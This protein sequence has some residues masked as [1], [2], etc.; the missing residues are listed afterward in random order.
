MTPKPTLSTILKYEAVSLHKDVCGLLSNQ[1]DPK[2]ISHESFRVSTAHTLGCMLLENARHDLSYS[3]LLQRTVS[4]H[5]YTEDGTIRR[6][7][8]L[9]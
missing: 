5:L 7:A 3:P 2:H 8:Y 9:D 1:L 4:T 6:T